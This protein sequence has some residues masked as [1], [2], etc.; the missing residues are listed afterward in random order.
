MAPEKKITAELC[1]TVYHS[2]LWKGGIY[3][4]K[5]KRKVASYQ[6][7]IVSFII[8]TAWIV[9]TFGEMLSP[10][11][12][13][14]NG[15]VTGDCLLVRTDIGMHGV[16]VPAP[17][18]HLWPPDCQGRMCTWAPGAVPSHLYSLPSTDPCRLLQL[19]IQ[20]HPPTQSYLLL[21][22]SNAEWNQVLK[23][24]KLL[25]ALWSV[26]TGVPNCIT[27]N[28]GRDQ[29]IAQNIACLL[30]LLKLSRDHSKTG[31]HTS[32]WE[33]FPYFQLLAGLYKTRVQA[34]L[35]LQNFCIQVCQR[36]KQSKQER[37]E[38]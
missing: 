12:A 2:G 9:T 22:C 27:Y 30:S 21:F 31:S 5:E 28:S 10:K 3:K 18:L 16:R 34:L 37:G 20:S 15:Q 4:E 6:C 25:V 19:H 38:K 14:E 8:R 29:K 17:G 35:W 36:L 1:M 26:W 32:M 33:R 13:S 7:F 11:H 24:H 23:P